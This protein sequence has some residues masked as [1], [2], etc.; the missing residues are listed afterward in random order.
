[1][2]LIAFPAPICQRSL[3]PTLNSKEPSAAEKVERY[4]PFSDHPQ[5]KA[6]V[7]IPSSSLTMPFREN[8]LA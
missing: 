8:E 2:L 6:S 7:G 1:M 3:G 5:T 4:P